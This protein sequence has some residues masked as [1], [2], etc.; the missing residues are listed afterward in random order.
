MLRV[1]CSV[2]ALSVLC[3]ILKLRNLGYL[4][5]DCVPIARFSRPLGAVCTLGHLGWVGI[6]VGLTVA[7]IREIAVSNEN[8]VTRVP[9]KAP[10]LEQK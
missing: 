8:D 10:A 1:L 4:P 5:A 7:A 2:T 6:Q 3:P 9:E